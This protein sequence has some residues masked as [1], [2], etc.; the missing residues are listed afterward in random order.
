MVML[1]LA[2]ILSVLRWKPIW[3]EVWESGLHLYL[4]AQLV[5]RRNKRKVGTCNSRAS[6]LSLFSLSPITGLW[7]WDLHEC[8]Q[9]L[10]QC[11]CGHPER[12]LFSSWGQT[13]ISNCN[14][15][16]RF[17]LLISGVHNTVPIMK[18]RDQAIPAWL[19]VRCHWNM[20]ATYFSGHGRL[21]IYWHFHENDL[22]HLM[23]SKMDWILKIWS[24]WN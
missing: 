17:S 8:G 24:L 4:P 22:N 20:G 11:L 1:I 12:F 9:K 16:Y 23:P 15:N 18:G 5:E 10:L 7:G 13:V 19:C 3:S 21:D 6:S 2:C 14:D